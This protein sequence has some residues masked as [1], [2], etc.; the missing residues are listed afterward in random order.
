MQNDLEIASKEIQKNQRNL[1]LRILKS[2]GTY[3]TMQIKADSFGPIDNPYSIGLLT[4]I[5]D[6]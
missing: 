2:N 4:P 1:E 5:E 3:C 6:K